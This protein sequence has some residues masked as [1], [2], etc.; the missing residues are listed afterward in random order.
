MFFFFNCARRYLEIGISVIV[1]LIFFYDMEISEGQF[2]NDI[3]YLYISRKIV[4]TMRNFH[5]GCSYYFCIEQLKW[6]MYNCLWYTNV[7]LLLSDELFN[8]EDIR[9]VCLRQAYYGFCLGIF[10]TFVQQIY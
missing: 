7:Q 8:R 10:E 3:A 9:C 4:L 1:L 5:S 6:I 2:K